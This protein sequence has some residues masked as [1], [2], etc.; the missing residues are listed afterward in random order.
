MI[1]SLQIVTKEPNQARTTNQTLHSNICHHVV[2]HQ[3][4]WNGFRVSSKMVRFRIDVKSSPSNTMRTSTMLR[5]RY[6]S[7]RKVGSSLDSIGWRL[8]V[9]NSVAY[10]IQT[11]MS[12]VRAYIHIFLWLVLNIDP[13]LP[14]LFRRPL[15]ETNKCLFIT[16]LKLV[17]QKFAIL[18]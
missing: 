14:S 3:R 8:K 7:V 13:G 9:R 4:N 11:R 17:H 18:T 12:P 15:N 2:M 16:V 1:S 6:R 10:S 5:V